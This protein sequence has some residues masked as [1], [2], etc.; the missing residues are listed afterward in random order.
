MMIEEL[1][2]FDANKKIEEITDWIRDWFQNN[3]PTASAVIGLSLSDGFLIVMLLALILD[4]TV[5]FI[6][7]DLPDPSRALQVITA[8]PAPMAVTVA[9]GDTLL[10]DPG[11]TI[12]TFSLE[13]IHS[14]VLF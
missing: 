12:A 13:D 14:T 3:G 10:S 2:N 4:E 6:L 1:K 7:A 5:T 9:L 11:S 8:L